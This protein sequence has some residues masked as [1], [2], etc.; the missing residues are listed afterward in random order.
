MP[1]PDER[2]AIVGELRTT[3]QVAAQLGISRLTVVQ[4]AKVMQVGTLLEIGMVFLPEEVAA[5]QARDW[6]RGRKPART[7]GA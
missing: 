3:G 4:R 1:T 7:D 6:T 2:K 5:M